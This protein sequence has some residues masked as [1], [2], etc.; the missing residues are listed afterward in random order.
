MTLFTKGDCRKCDYLKGKIDLAALGVQ[1]EELGPENADAL[2]HLAWHELV[3]VAEK[4]LPILVL[5]DSS[6]L[7]DVIPILRY[8]RE[9]QT[10][11]A[12]PSAAI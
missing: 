10:A 11:T 2:A 1:V 12:T 6:Y 9:I 4:Q 7:T 5:D 8:L 3:T